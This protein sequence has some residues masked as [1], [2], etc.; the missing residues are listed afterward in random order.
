MSMAKVPQSVPPGKTPAPPSARR[1]FMIQVGAWIVG[2]IVSLVPLA[3]GLAVFLD[4]MRRRGTGDKLFRVTTLDAFPDDGIPRQF[5]I[6]AEH[7]DAWNRSLEPVG[8]VYLRRNK[9]EATPECLTATCPHAGCFVNYDLQANT[10]KCPC[11]NSTFGVDGQ[12]IP[13]SPS[14]RAMDMLECEVKDQE[15]LVKFQNFYT[16]KTEKVVKA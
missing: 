11:H 9:G 16:G 7:V 15:I 3:S 4:P 10:F 8:A 13:P 12:I 5:P 14:P 6:I 1:G 2:G